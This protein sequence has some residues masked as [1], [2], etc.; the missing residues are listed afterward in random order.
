MLAR[1]D[2]VGANRLGDVLE[3]LFAPILEANVQLTLHLAVHLFGNQDAAWIGC[4]FQP[5]GDVDP[6]A[7]KIAAGSNDYV[8]KI[9][10][11]AQLEAIAVRTET[12][13]HLNRASHGGQGTGEL[14]KCAIARCLD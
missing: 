8:T 6:V 12:I 1:A 10:P 5:D 7:K 14:G 9:D 4:P 11:D 2:S 3:L 13:L